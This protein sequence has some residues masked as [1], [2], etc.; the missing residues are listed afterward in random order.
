[1]MNIGWLEPWRARWQELAPRERRAVSIAAV[2]FALFLVYALVWSPMQS[3]IARLRTS[4]PRM[5]TQLALMESQAREVAQLRAH[6]P[7]VTQSGNL[8]SSLEQS[9][10]SQG[11]RQSITRIDPEGGNAAHIS[12]D[13]VGFNALLTWLNDL[14]GQGIRVDTATIQRRDAPGMVSARLLV[15]APGG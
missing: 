2:V 6:A 11:L 5:Q 10:V 8:L 1:M 4:V 15:R 3:T 12:F 9:A 13:N 7:A 14:Q